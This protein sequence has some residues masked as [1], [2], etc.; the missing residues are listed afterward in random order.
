MRDFFRRE[1]AP[2]GTDDEDGPVELLESG[3]MYR[4]GLR[5]NAKAGQAADDKPEKHSNKKRADKTG[6]QTNVYQTDNAIGS[7][8]ATRRGA[9]PANAAHHGG[10][11][12][13]SPALIA[14]CALAPL[15]GQG[16]LMAM[17]L[18]VL[19]VHEAAHI[20]CARVLGVPIGRLRLTPLGASLELDARLITPRNEALIAAAGPIASALCVAVLCLLTGHGLDDAL[21]IDTAGV[22]LTLTLFNLMPAS[23]LDGGRILHA[24]LRKRFGERRASDVC[25]IL[26]MIMALWLMACVLVSACGGRLPVMLMAA[27]VCVFSLAAGEYMGDT[28]TAW[29]LAWT[30]GDELRRGGCLPVRVVAVDA[31]TPVRA[32]LRGLRRGETTV[33]RVTDEQ[34][35]CLGE[36]SETEL[37]TRCVDDPDAKARVLLGV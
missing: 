21:L 25:G 28:Q 12:S 6:T 7:R 16:R 29:Q 32:L 35:H 18:G 4:A 9:R 10:F 13:V 23:P 17:T 37:L 15:L 26:G 5:E 14:L 30:H 2:I 19:A 1:F 33:F 36:I 22:A 8:K 34:M 27:A 3:R 20:T 24:L 31:D 11:I